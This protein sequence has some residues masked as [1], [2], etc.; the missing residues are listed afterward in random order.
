[1]YFARHRIARIDG[2]AVLLGDVRYQYA[3]RRD[4]TEMRVKLP[5]ETSQ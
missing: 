1:M 4:W 3:N 2:D 5:A